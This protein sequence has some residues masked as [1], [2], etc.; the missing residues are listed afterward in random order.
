MP[1]PMRCYN[2]CPDSEYQALLDAEAKAE[3]ELAEAMP[4]AR[5]VYFPSPG[6]YQVWRDYRPV[7]GFEREFHSRI[8][9]I[10]AALRGA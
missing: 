9:A 2:G 10:D 1:R 4:G 5:C 6:Y 7:L 3:R 8:A